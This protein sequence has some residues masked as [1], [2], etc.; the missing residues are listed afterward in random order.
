MVA[1]F[2]ALSPERAFV[3]DVGRVVRA[4]DVR[5]AVQA[6]PREQVGSR[7]PARR[8]LRAG[9]ACLVAAMARRLV[10]LLAQERRP[11]PQQVVVHRAVRVMAERA[12]LLHRL[13]PGHEAAAPFSLATVRRLLHGPPY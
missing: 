5:V 11:L 4:V 8:V 1:P 7:A 6:A 3:G 12:V 9:E 10:A 2:P 13:V